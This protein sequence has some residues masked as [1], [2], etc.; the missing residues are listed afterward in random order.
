M[1]PLPPLTRDDDTSSDRGRG[2]GVGGETGRES[3]RLRRPFIGF[4]GLLRL[5]CTLARI[6][7]IVVSVPCGRADAQNIIRRVSRRDSP[8]AGMGGEYVYV[9]V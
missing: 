8:R 9:C 1:L 5:S 2:G 7:A 4:A 6:Y 3:T